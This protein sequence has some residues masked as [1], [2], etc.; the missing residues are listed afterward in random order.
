M[1]NRDDDDDHVLAGLDLHRWRVP[2]P[3]GDPRAILQ[4]AL[5][6]AAP[7]RRRLRW[8]VA[9]MA[10]GNVVLAAILAIVVTRPPDTIRIVQPAGG[11]SSE[12]RELLQRL[13]DER[14]ELERRLAEI[15]ELRALV[16]Q[17]DDKLQRYEQ[18][19]VARPGPAPQPQQQQPPPLPAPPPQPGPPLADRSERLDRPIISAGMASVRVRV[20]ACKTASTPPGKVK[21]HVDVAPAGAVTSVDVTETPD[22]ALGTCVASA[23]RTAHFTS[24]QQGG[25]F[26]YPYV[27]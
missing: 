17:L 27:F 13:D 6:P 22:R 3:I 5:A 7:P 26:S 8:L 1:M 9:G 2:P 4:R 14:R 12:V 11:P 10:V 24:T 20:E 25:S 21:V 23:V 16:Q 19:T 15:D 18:H